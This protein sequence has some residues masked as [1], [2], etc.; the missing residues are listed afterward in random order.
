MPNLDIATV[1]QSEFFTAIAPVGTSGTMQATV[2]S[3]GLSQLSPK[4]TVYAL[5]QLT[6]L[7]SANGSSQYGT[8]LTVSVPNVT[9]GQIFFPASLYAFALTGNHGWALVTPVGG[10]CYLAAWLALA[11]GFARRGAP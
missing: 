7:G 10:L 1:G 8:T 2:Q 5:D 6:V 11:I 9:A 3:K 4:L